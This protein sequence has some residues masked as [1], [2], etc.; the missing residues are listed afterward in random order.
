MQAVRS[1]LALTWG[2]ETFHTPMVEHTDEMVM[3]VDSSLL[4]IGRCREGEHVVI[5]A[6]SPPG[7]PGSTNALRIHRMGDALHEVAPAYRAGTSAEQARAAA[8]LPSGTPWRL[9]PRS[10]RGAATPARATS[11]GRRRALVRVPV[12]ASGTRDRLPSCRRHGGTYPATGRP[13][14]RRQQVGHPPV[15]W[16]EGCGS[17]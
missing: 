6:G 10:R 17:A 9:S 16:D 7:I 3:Q 4:E 2:V 13:G 12:E 5:V 15:S 11:T 8:A 14:E 1:Q